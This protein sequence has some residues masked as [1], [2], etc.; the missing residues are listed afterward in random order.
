MKKSLTLIGSGGH[1][2][3]IL[4]CINVSK[5]S[6]VNSVTWGDQ[7]INSELPVAHIHLNH[8]SDLHVSELNEFIIAIGEISLRSVLIAELT[9]LYPNISF[10]NVIAPNAFIARGVK[11]GNGVFI[12]NGAYVGPDCH[13]GSHV[14]LNTACIIE[15]DCS[16]FDSVVVSPSVVIG[17]ET[18]IE[19]QAFIGIGATVRDHV[20]IGKDSIIGAG[21]LVLGD[22][23]PGSLNYGVPS[24]LIR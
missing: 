17:G 6:E 19:H 20:R 3:S 13:I 24:K 5:Y 4:S 16:I 10:V 15:H 11:L 9:T 18:V 23:T 1:S 12:G 21:S 22:T 14:I 2:K 7:F 8:L